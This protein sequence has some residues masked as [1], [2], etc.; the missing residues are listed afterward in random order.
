MTAPEPSTRIAVR[1]GW[2]SGR[3][4][5][6]RPRVSTRVIP[7]GT[8]YALASQYTAATPASAR[9]PRDDAGRRWIQIA[10]APTDT[11]NPVSEQTN[12][13]IADIRQS[14]AARRQA[15]SLMRA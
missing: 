8:T 13:M 10:I 7:Y 11:I 12:S 6:R 14:V 5:G 4:N 1:R 15:G 9:R 3:E 2:P